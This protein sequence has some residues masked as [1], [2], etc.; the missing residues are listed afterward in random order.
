MLCSKKITFLSI[1]LFLLA[2]LAS[3]AP[4]GAGDDD[5]KV[6]AAF[7]KGWALFGQMHKD[8][9]NLDLAI[10]QYNDVLTM[11][12]QNAD[13]LWK[14]SETVFKKAQYSKDEKKKKEFLNQSLEYAEKAMA[15]APKKPEPRYW[16]AVNC[17]M[18]AESM[19]NIKGLGL[20][21]RAKKELNTAMK[22]DPK[23][24]FTVLSKAM[25]ANIS[26]DSPWPVRDLDKAEK[27]AKEAVAEDPNLTWAS[28][29]L[30]R[31]YAKQGKTEL[32]KKE[33]NRCI[34]ISKPTYGWDSVLYDW[35]MAKSALKELK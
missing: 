28:C 8:M 4:A 5:P 26:L 2:A 25:L 12:P 15:L 16:I 10:K 30:G 23:N 33:L 21:N 6:K 3:N 20:A 11:Y 17:A 1:T 7:E 24:R 31:S 29:L 35:P 13:A 14:L 32:A 9:K 27:L 34:A 19:H 22:L 18:M